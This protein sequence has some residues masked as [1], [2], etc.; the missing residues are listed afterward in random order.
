MDMETEMGWKV[1]YE[2]GE[3]WRLKPLNKTPAR[4]RKLLVK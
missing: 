1:F 2:E 3:E 4:V